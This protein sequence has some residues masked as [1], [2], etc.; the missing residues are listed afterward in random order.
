MHDGPPTGDDIDAPA[1][2][3]PALAWSTAFVGLALLHLLNAPYTKVEESFNVQAAHDMLY[4]RFDLTAYDH[5]EFPG[6]VPRTFVGT[7]GCCPVD[8]R[9]LA[10]ART[11]QILIRSGA[12]TLAV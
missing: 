11:C 12:I 7:H 9:L 5:L 2:L 1:M 8:L 6:V 3:L 10:S 4:L